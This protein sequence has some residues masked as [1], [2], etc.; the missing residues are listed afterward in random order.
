MCN[1]QDVDT[2]SL[3]EMK[4]TIKVSKKKG[5]YHQIEKPNISSAFKNASKGLRLSK[6]RSFTNL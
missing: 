2:L 5:R 3:I 6:M 1:Y 4:W